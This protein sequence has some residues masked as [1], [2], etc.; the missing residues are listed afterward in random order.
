MSNVDNL[1]EAVRGEYFAEQNTCERYKLLDKL[2]TLIDDIRWVTTEQIK[3]EEAYLAK[4][5]DATDVSILAE[6]SMY[7]SE[8]SGLEVFVTRDTVVGELKGIGNINTSK[9]VQLCVM[10]EVVLQRNVD[11][12]IPME[13]TLGELIDS[14]KK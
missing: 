5:P 10:I 2:Q 12:M 3:S 13:A 4:F 8:A 7:V 9:F 11:G 14:C 6:L 1:I